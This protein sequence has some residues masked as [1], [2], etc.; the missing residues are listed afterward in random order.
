MEQEVREAMR[1]AEADP[2]IRAIVLTGAGRGFC[3]GADMS[4]LSGIAQNGLNPH[5]GEHALSNSATGRRNPT[6]V[7]IS[8]RSIRTFRP[9]RSR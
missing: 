8:R 1:N 9:S 2:D 3:A 5:G 6:S 4:L 7:P